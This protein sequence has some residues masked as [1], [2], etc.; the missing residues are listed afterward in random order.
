MSASASCGQAIP[1]VLCC[2]VPLADSCTAAKASLLDDLVGASTKRPAECHAEDCSR[3]GLLIDI[4]PRNRSAGRAQLCRVA[5]RA[6]A[7]G[8]EVETLSAGAEPLKVRSELE[9][10]RRLAF[11]L[12]LIARGEVIG[13]EWA[14]G[15]R[16]RLPAMAASLVRRQ[17]SVIVASGGGAAVARVAKQATTTIPIVFVVAGDPVRLGLVDALNRPGGNVTGI[18]LL[19]SESGG[20]RLELLRELL[21]KS[22]RTRKRC[23]AHMWRWKRPASDPRELCAGHLDAGVEDL[24]AHAQATGS[25]FSTTCP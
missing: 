2:F 3:T 5:H 7:H 21:P 22:K 19:L 18:N 10:G 6:R 11:V 9:I 8:G 13:S 25:R 23:K 12:E 1:Y 16:D 4:V 14:E 17:V 20:K 24:V 15:Q